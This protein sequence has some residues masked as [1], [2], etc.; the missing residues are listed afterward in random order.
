MK[1]LFDNTPLQLDDILFEGRNKK[2]GAYALRNEADAILTKSLIMGLGLF[3]VIAVTPM[4]LTVFKAPETAAP[5]K[6]PVQIELKNVF[7]AEKPQ[8]S[9][10]AA[11]PA[12]PAA[13]ATYD[14][15]LATPTR[16]ARVETVLPKHNAPVEA[17]PGISDIAGVPPVTTV[18][19]PSLPA[20][21][22]T[23]IVQVPQVQV[24][25]TPKTSVDVEANFAGGI[26]AF[27]NKVINNFD[28]SAVESDGNVL[29]TVV[30]FI[31][32]RDGSISD[33]K[34]TGPNSDFN[35][36]AE[37]TIR[38]VKGKWV[39]AKIGNQNVRSY[40]KFPISMQVQ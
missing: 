9:E 16:H 40:F 30:I 32:E 26:N 23:D 39:P 11:V 5:P 3:V 34:A 27:R 29:K 13:V 2:Y 1:E 4:V 21:S 31:V 14:S 10:V 7:Q 19:P 38:S 6:I 18:A 28:T 36:V 37:R 17:A 22:T 15:R 25:N 33:I 35:R 20:N 8:K 12:Q 24:Y